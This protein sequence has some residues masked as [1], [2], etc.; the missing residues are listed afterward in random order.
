ML[1]AV[2][3]SSRNEIPSSSV[4]PPPCF[5]SSVS[6]GS[7]GGGVL[8][9][10][11][12]PKGVPVF[13]LFSCHDERVGIVRVEA[14]E[15]AGEFVISFGKM[16]IRANG[17]YIWLKQVKETFWFCHYSYFKDVFKDSAFYRG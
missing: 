5:V 12:R 6:A 13:R 10:M 11:I 1:L 2:E 9:I 4:F 3:I 15:R 17:F 16:F 14:Y 7:E 8:P